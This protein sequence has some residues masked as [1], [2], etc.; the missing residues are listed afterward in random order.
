MVA[1]CTNAAKP[2]TSRCSHHH[3]GDLGGGECASEIPGWVGQ[4]C[5]R[6]RRRHLITYF[7]CWGAPRC[8]PPT[9][10]GCRALHRRRSRAVSCVIIL[11]RRTSTRIYRSH[12]RQT[13]C[14]PYSDSRGRARELLVVKPRPTGLTRV[15]KLHFGDCF[16]DHSLCIAVLHDLAQDGAGAICPKRVKR[17]RARRSSGCSFVR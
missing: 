14:L 9:H 2:T 4:R 6:L 7:R 16:G 17:T 5:F 11:V 12:Q 3:N 8:V 10:F 13:P 15:P 1:T